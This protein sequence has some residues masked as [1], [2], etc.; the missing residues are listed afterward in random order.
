LLRFLGARAVP[1]IES[2]EGE[3]YRRT[4]RLPAGRGP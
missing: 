1:G 4:L 3:V 2:Y